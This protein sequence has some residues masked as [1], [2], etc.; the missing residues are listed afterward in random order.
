MATDEQLERWHTEGFDA[1][2]ACTSDE[3][4]RAIVRETHELL[5]DEP[6]Y[7]DVGEDEHPC[8]HDYLLAGAAGCLFE[9]IRQC[10]E[11]ARIEDYEIEMAARTR[12]GPADT[13]DELPETVEFRITDLDVDIQVTVPDEYEAR[14]NRCLDLYEQYCPISQSLQAGID[15]NPSATLD[16]KG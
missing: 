11:R 6:E 2:L 12:K 8:P 7:I 1:R 15:V 16:V 9:T 13:P 4:P 10:L 3:A 5:Y 14:A